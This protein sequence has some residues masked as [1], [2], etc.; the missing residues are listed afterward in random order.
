ME[1]NEKVLWEKVGEDHWVVTLDQDP[2]TGELLL[3]M[4]DEVLTKNGWVEGDTL[5]WDVN[6][7]TG[8]VTL[9]KQA[10]NGSD[11]SSS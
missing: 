4:P 6:V 9:T 5:V 8:T 3:P 1:S 10:S 11:I 7:E 2:E